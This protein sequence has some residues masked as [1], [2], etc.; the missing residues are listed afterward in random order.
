[1]PDVQN[2]MQVKTPAIIQE[3]NMKVR[4]FTHLVIV[5]LAKYKKEFYEFLGPAPS[6][7]KW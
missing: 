4:K 5:K 3:I 6:E 2:I 1:M 7:T